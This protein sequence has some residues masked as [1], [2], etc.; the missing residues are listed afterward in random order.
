MQRETPRRKRSAHSASA[1][2]RLSARA[3]VEPRSATDVSPPSWRRERTRA[4]RKAGEK[5]TRGERERER[6]TERG[7]RKRERERARRAT[8]TEAL[9]IRRERERE[10]E[11]EGKTVVARRGTFRSER[12]RE[13]R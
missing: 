3:R 5:D 2:S 12:E 11:R 6:E 10:R 7:G 13:S 4:V 9:G 8:E 1:I